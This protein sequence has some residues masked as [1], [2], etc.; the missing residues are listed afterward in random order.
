M[1]LNNVILSAA[2]AAAFTMNAQAASNGVINFKGKI[3]DQTCDVLI[4]GQASPATVTLPTVSTSTLANAG[5]VTGQTHFNIE[6]SNCTSGGSVM[7]YFENGSTVDATTKMLK[8]TLTGATAATN[9]QLQLI[10]AST[11]TAIQAGNTNQITNTT[12]VTIDSSMAAVL[13]YAVEYYSL[14]GT[15]AGDVE[16]SVSFTIHYQ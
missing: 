11:G 14:G 9:V 5:D 12:K 6:L 4:D 10:D 16:S 1:K 3:V 8:N 7:S 2:I 13:P 15:T